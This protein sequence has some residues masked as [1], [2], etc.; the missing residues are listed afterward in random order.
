MEFASKLRW[1]LVIFILLFVLIFVGWGLSAV[2]RSVFNRSSND[3]AVVV[4]EFESSTLEGVS[5]VR[6]IVDGPVVASA[7]H[8]S[9]QIEISRNVVSMKLLSDYGQ[10]VLAEKTY[11]NNSEAFDTFIFSLENANATARYESTDVEDDFADQGVCPDGRRYII[12]L[13]EDIRR[14]TTSCDRT[15]GTAAG[16]MTTMRGLF[17]K[18]IPDFKEMI[19]DTSLNRR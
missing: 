10:T 2:A 13:G 4:D 17:Q 18:Q 6:Y 7:E 8:R 15:Q 19:K 9:Y 11:K 12:E 16:K 14:W 3:A 5:A 1:V